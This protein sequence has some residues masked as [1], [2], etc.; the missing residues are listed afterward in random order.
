LIFAAVL[1]AGLEFTGVLPT[2]E[3][4]TC[5]VVS[6]CLVVVIIIMSLAIDSAASSAWMPAASAMPPEMGRASSATGNGQH[7]DDDSRIEDETKQ[8]ARHGRMNRGKAAMDGNGL[9]EAEQ[10]EVG[11]LKKIDRAVR[12]HEAQHIAAGGALVKGGASFSYQTG[13][14]GQRYAVGGEVSIDTSKGRTPEETVNRARRI[15]AAALAPADPSP[16][17]RSVAAFASQMEMQAMREIAQAKIDE[18]AESASENAPEN[19]AGET[20]S[21]TRTDSA[22]SGQDGLAPAAG[23]QNTER[24]N[25][26]GAIKPGMAV[27]AYQQASRLGLEG[28]RDAKGQ[29]DASVNAAF[30][31]ARRQMARGLSVFA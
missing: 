25:G 28:A 19:A 26:M 14:D 3:N 29:Q 2:I 30:G 6:F 27:S 17:D 4:L 7:A 9:S 20:P 5:L 16:Q 21:D 11:E 13:P 15:R 1:C 24:A 18:A 22:K 31:G 10:R 8:G 12:Q 23:R